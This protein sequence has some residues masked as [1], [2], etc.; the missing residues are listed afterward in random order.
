MI[1][2]IEPIPLD[3][4]TLIIDRP[5]LQGR[6]QRAFW[7][8]VTALAWFVWAYLW[9]PLVTLVAWFLGARA[10]VR[11]ALIPDRMTFLTSGLL[12]LVVV[13]CLALLLVG[14]S[15]Y[16]LHRFGGEDRRKAAAPVPRE[17]VMEAFGIDAPSLDRLRGERRI[18]LHHGD[19][20]ELVG[21]EGSEDMERLA[22]DTSA[23]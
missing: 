20:G 1:P 6:T 16:N 23:A 7:G 9:L 8:G 3:R 11:E 12:Y 5:N 21:V 22:A 10:F 15:R 13:L 18:R 17:A 4:S 14:W 19:A 2:P